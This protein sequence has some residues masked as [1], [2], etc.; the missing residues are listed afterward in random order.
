MR[1][2]VCVWKLKLLFFFEFMFFFKKKK[3]NES[4]KFHIIFVFSI[5][6][7]YFLLKK[8]KKYFQIYL[9]LN[10]KIF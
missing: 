4:I 2:F 5:L 3:Y 1:E 10:Y 7:G 6:I 9:Q 8:G